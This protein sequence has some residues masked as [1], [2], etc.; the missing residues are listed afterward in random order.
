MVGGKNVPFLNRRWG[1]SIY[2]G[3]IWRGGCVI[4]SFVRCMYV[5]YNS[6]ACGY[7]NIGE[8]M[9]F[10]FEYCGVVTIAIFATVVFICFG[11]GVVVRG[12]RRIFV[13]WK[14]IWVK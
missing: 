3:N 1:Y 10:K 2:G 6:L 14:G 12:L 11:D 5:V 7:S 8:G 13:S 4:V 9:I